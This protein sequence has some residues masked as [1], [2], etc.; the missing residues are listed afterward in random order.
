MDDILNRA[1]KMEG[2][3][4]LKT[5]KLTQQENSQ[6]RRIASFLSEGSPS[7]RGHKRTQPWLVSGHYLN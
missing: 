1:E 4:S 2:R 5:T 7:A 6:D 3:Q